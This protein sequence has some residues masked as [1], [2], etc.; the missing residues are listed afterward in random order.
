MLYIDLPCCKHECLRICSIL[1]ITKTKYSNPIM[2]RLVFQKPLVFHIFLY[3]C[4]PIYP[5]TSGLFPHH[6]TICLEIGELSTLN[7]NIYHRF[8]LQKMP[9]GGIPHVQT[10]PHVTLH[11]IT[12]YFHLIQSVLLRVNTIFPLINN[13]TR[14]QPLHPTSGPVCILFI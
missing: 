13:E 6:I 9:F 10:N 12:A 14:H 8:P 4:C 11:N 3:V 1:P 2:A 7:L 5:G